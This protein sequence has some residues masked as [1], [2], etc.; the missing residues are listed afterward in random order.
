MSLKLSIYCRPLPIPI[1][2]V[3]HFHPLKD[4]CRNSEIPYTMCMTI[5]YYVLLVFDIS[6]VMAPSR[7]TLMTDALIVGNVMDSVTKDGVILN[8]PQYL[9]VHV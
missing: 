4:L 2:H 8:T 9:V 1:T 7:G 6:L 3:K 5:K